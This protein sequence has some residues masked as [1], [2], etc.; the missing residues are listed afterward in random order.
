VDTPDRTVTVSATAVNRQ[1]IS[2]PDGAM[3]TIEDDD[4]PTVTVA[5][6]GD[7]TEGEYA[8]FTLTRAG[9]L[10]EPLTVA[11]TL[12]DGT[13]SPPLVKPVGVTFGAGDATTALRLATRQNTTVAPD[14]TVTLALEDGTA[15]RTGTQS[16]ATVT[17]R[18]DDEQPVSIAGADPVVEGG[19]LEFP[20][21]LT[22]S[23]D[24]QAAVSYT[25]AGAATAGTDHAGGASGTVTFAPGV[26]RG[27]I[28]IVTLV[29]DLVEPEEEVRVSVGGVV[30]LHK[31]RG[32]MR[33]IESAEYAIRALGGAIRGVVEY[34][35]DDSGRLILTIDKI[36]PTPDAYPRRPG[37]PAKR[38]LAGASR[39]P[40]RTC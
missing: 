27:T 23:F 11:A 4:E 10:A 9:I 20:V 39:P 29:D 15:W 24:T 35:G 12:T 36:A 38:P 26:M 18:D 14:A 13:Q 6:D 25:L 30:A 40:R 1:G 31:T 22:R 33:E 21:T 16:R 28:R 8:A 19:T 7:V 37:I 34:G 17:V 2:G 5:S 3:L 32:A